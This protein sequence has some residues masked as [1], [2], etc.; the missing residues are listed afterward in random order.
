M[1]IHTIGTVQYGISPIRQA[2]GFWDKVRRHVQNAQQNGVKLLVFPEYL[3]AHML[4]TLPAMETPEACEYLDARTDEYMSTFMQISRETGITI[5]A[6]THICKD[7]A[8]FVNAAFLFFPD[9]RI[10][11]QKKIHLTPEERKHWPLAAGDSYAVFDTEV[12]RAAILICYDIEF[13]EGP[14]IVAD[15]GAQIILCPSYT[16]AAAGYYRVRYCAQARAVENQLY[17]AL[18]GI[19]G[20][21]PHVPQIDVGYCQA[22]IFA[23][24]DRPFPANGILAS[25]KTNQNALVTYPLDFGLLKEN[26][27]HGNVSPYFDRKQELYDRYRVLSNK[28]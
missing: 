9:G 3:T 14:R 12:G 24:C 28:R 6:G 16:D 17:V 21:L 26:R 11:K 23:P 5:L 20:S 4:G 13:P 7:G 18:S 2:K 27:E 10:E 8:D 1:T 19:V 25:G 15:M 22:G